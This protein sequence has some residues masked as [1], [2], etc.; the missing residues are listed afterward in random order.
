MNNADEEKVVARLA[1]IIALECGIAPAKAKQIRV[2]ASLHDIGKLRIPA[3]ILNKP[4]K[5]TAAEFDVIKTH[6]TLGEAMLKSIQGELGELARLIARYHH[7]WY[8]GRGYWGRFTHEFP[9]AVSITAI[10]DVFTALCFDRPYKSAWPPEE[11]LA[12]IQKQSGAQFD[13]LLVE[14]FLPLV[15]DDSRVSAIFKV[16]NES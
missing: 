6:T 1:E 5:L 3:E 12:Y 4:G 13:P 9:A 16:S 10:A 11:A 14:V 15:R 2:A 7:E 8:S